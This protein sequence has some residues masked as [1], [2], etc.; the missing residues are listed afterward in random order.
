MLLFQTVLV[1][2][3]LIEDSE[4]LLLHCRLTPDASRVD[5]M[6]FHEKALTRQG[7]RGGPLF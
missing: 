3:T 7:Q 2:G 6:S 1:D 5:T 4:A